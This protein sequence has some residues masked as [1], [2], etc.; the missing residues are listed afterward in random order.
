[1]I[2]IS[3][4][5]ILL[6]FMVWQAKRRNHKT[7][8]RL[9]AVVIGILSGIAAVIIRNSVK[10]I[11]H[12]LTHGFDVGHE[13][14]LYFALPAIGIL[15]AVLFIRYVIKDTVGHGVPSIL[16]AISR[17]NGIIKRHNTFST[18]ITSMLTVGGN[19]GKEV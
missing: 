9:A 18:I 19:S 1:M 13:N 11:N 17:N 16:Y 5:S 2:K 15:L 3:R 14:I 8:I 12:L 4:Q 7:F 6:K 10:F